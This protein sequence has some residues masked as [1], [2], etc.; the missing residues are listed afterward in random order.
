MMLIGGGELDVRGVASSGGRAAA[1]EP[2]DRAVVG[3]EQ[4]LTG[5]V[6]RALRSRVAWVD[7]GSTA[8]SAKCRRGVGGVSGTLPGADVRGLYRSLGI[9]LPGRAAREA[10]V[11]CFAD[12]GAHGHGD[13]D[14]VLLGEP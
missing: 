3:R 13:R 10:P 8:E 11:G 4:A 7:V 14:P 5:S 9:E 12:P 2:C 6:H 1:A